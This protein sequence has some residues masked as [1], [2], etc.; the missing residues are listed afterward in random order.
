MENLPKVS[1]IVTCY[2]FER[3]IKECF[4]SILIQNYPN[5]EIIVCD[6]ASNDHSA[7]IIMEYKKRFPQ[8]FVLELSEINGGLT[9]NINKGLKRVSGKYLAFLSGDDL[10][11]PGKLLKQVEHLENFPK[12]NLCYT[13]T[14]IFDSENPEK[15]EFNSSKEKQRSGNQSTVIMYGTFCGASSVMV[16]T[17]K[18]PR[19]FSKLVKY[20]AEWMYWVDCLKHGGEIHF[21]NEPLTKYRRH[22]RNV[23]NTKNLRIN[24]ETLAQACFLILK[25]PWQAP[26]ALYRIGYGF[27]SVLGRSIARR[28]FYD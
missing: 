22:E 5:L 20:T 17:E 25:Y 23:T 1:V 27:Y 6:D 3:Y 24:L 13:D 8:L 16:R 11:E 7:E 14:I 19:A 28:K 4:E 9:T 21:I 18:A 12:C 26:F 10:F 2:N 15:Y